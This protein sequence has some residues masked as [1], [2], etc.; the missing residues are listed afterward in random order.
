MLGLQQQWVSSSLNP[1]PYH[2][3]ELEKA[4]K[5][6]PNEMGGGTS[7]PQSTDDQSAFTCAFKLYILKE[8][9]SL[10]GIENL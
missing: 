6:Q 2:D 10:Q 3:P 4:E 1:A 7:D 8:I 9:R 5:N